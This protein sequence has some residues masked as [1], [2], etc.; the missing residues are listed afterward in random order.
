MKES[1]FHGILATE[2]QGRLV[3]G[4]GVP[5]LGGGV[6]H[7]Y[8]EDGA[9]GASSEIQRRKGRFVSGEGFFLVLEGS[10]SQVP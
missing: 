8:R 7:C 6:G 3:Q 5:A 9:W 10:S 4:L 1:D 2:P